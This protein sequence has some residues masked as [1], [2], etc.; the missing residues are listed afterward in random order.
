MIEIKRNQ[1]YGS[2]LYGF[3]RE[4]LRS[5]NELIG[6]KGRKKKAKKAI[7]ETKDD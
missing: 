5:L 2:G 7:K 6:Q 1:E 4:E 3:T